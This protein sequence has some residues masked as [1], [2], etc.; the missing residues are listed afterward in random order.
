MAE[1]LTIPSKPNGVRDNFGNEWRSLTS[2]AKELGVSRRR[3][4]AALNEKQV[5]KHNGRVYTLADTE[6]IRVKNTDVIEENV[7]NEGKCFASGANEVALSMKDYEEYMAMKEA[8]GLPFETYEISKSEHSKGLRYAIALFSDAHIEETV[9]PSTVLGMNEYNLEIAE[10]RVKNYFSNL[11]TC[12]NKDNVEELIFAALGDTISG[13]IHDELAQTN[14]MTP[15]EATIKAQSLIY[16]GLKYLCDNT[17]L[18]NIRFVGIVGNHSRVTKRVQHSNGYKM[19]YEWI[20]YQNIKNLC[21]VTKLPI[22]FFI[23]ESEVAV[24]DIA[25]KRFLFIHGFQIKSTGS[26]TVCG[27]YPAL[28]RLAMKWDRTFHQDKIYLGHF[29][30]CVSIPNVTVNG[31][32]IGYNSFALTNGFTYEDPAQ[33]YELYDSERGLLLTR[34]I[35]CD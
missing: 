31:S 26:G 17:R 30:T 7:L 20:M 9:Q 22:D 35:Y 15:S 29:H 2:L 19:S 10:E 12:V 3:L 4:T 24:I 11:A 23:P 34:K 25:D 13:F 28:N 32:I 8:S 27:I 33:M 5:F 16:S 18:K 6:I 1:K 21:E 14:G